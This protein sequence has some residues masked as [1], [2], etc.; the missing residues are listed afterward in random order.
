LE[1]IAQKINLDSYKKLTEKLK[2]KMNNWD[3]NAFLQYTELVKIAKKYWI[4]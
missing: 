4:K 1:K 2:E 3:D